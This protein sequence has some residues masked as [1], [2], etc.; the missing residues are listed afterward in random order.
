[1]N[2]VKDLLLDQKPL[3]KGY[4]DAV[5]IQKMLIDEEVW[6]AQQYSGEGLAAVDKNENLAY[7]IPREGAP[8]WV[9]FFAMPR[10]AKNKEEAHVFLNYILRPEVNAS[11]ASE[12]WYATSN[13][14][15]KPLMDEEVTQSPSVYPSSEVLA[16][17]EFFLDHE[18]ETVSFVNRIW[19]KLT[20]KD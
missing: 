17:C 12:L 5:T 15:A 4:L 20:V 10:D 8:V 9:D 16:R 6:A 1:L 11:I 13:K 18:G 14:A 3:L 7:V 2:N 19:V